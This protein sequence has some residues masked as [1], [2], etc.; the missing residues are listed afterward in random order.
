MIAI[1]VKCT[2]RPSTDPAAPQPVASGTARKQRKRSIAAGSFPRRSV[3]MTAKRMSSVPQTSVA[4]ENRFPD[5]A[6][7][8]SPR[9]RCSFLITILRSTICR[10]PEHTFT[11]TSRQ[12]SGVSSLPSAW[13]R[14]PRARRGV[15]RGRRLAF[16]KSDQCPSG[17]RCGEA[18]L[19]QPDVIETASRNSDNIA[20]LIL[21]K[22]Q[23]V[24]DATHF[25]SERGFKVAPI[26]E[27]NAISAIATKS[28]PSEQSWTAVTLPFSISS[29]RTHQHAFRIE[30]RRMAAGRHFCPRSRATTA[31]EQDDRMKRRAGK[32][33]SPCALKPEVALFSQSS[34]RPTPP[35]AGVGRMARLLPSSFLVSL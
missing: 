10:R 3:R 5:R 27:I 6:S 16:G 4:D 14:S 21:A 18:A 12:N 25:I 17:R 26:P 29:E 31:S 30:D 33:P 15:R 24:S 8:M 19:A 1:S 23:A 34:S 11:S 20:A 35:M 7:H 28:P 2:T 13:G 32:Y 22:R 9:Q